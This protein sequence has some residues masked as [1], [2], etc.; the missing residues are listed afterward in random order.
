MTALAIAV[1]VHDAV[2]RY[3]SMIILVNQDNLVLG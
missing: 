1:R 2:P 3:V